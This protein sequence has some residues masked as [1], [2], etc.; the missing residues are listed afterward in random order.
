MDEPLKKGDVVVVSGA[1]YE[2]EY[3]ARVTRT[4]KA[5]VFVGRKDPNGMI[6]EMK[7]RPTGREVGASIR[8]GN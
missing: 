4:T 5:I 3:L 8:A 7:F 2:P 6:Y 1:G